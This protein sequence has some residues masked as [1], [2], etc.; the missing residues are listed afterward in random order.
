ML[1]AIIVEDDASEVPN[2]FLNMPEL[3]LLFSHIPAHDLLNRYASVTGDALF[4]HEDNNVANGVEFTL[5]NGQ[6]QPT[7]SMVQGKWTRMRLIFSSLTTSLELQMTSNTIGCEWHLL[8]KDGIYVEGAPRRFGE[9]VYMG[10][11]NRVDVV[12]KCASSGNVILGTATMANII[13]IVVSS[14][15]DIPD[16]ALP[17]FSPYRPDYLADVYTATTTTTFSL[18]FQGVNGGCTVNGNAWDGST[19]TGS[20]VTGSIQEWDVRGVNRHPFHIHVNSYQLSGVTSATDFFMAGDWHD[21]LYAPMGVTVDKYFFAVDSFVTKSVLHCHFLPHEDLGCMGYMQ[22]TG[23]AGAT[24]GLSGHGMSCL[25]TST[26]TGDGTAVYTSA[27]DLVTV[28]PS[29]EPSASPTSVP[30]S[31]P[32]SSPPSTVPTSHPSFTPTY[33]PSHTTSYQLK[34]QQVCLIVC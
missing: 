34:F 6:Y 2:V 32:I 4:S 26:A 13:T 22:H 15:A 7:A 18:N 21:V 28:A 9:T 29:S 25:G 24:T 12:M 10:P 31:M 17:Q 1:G 5:V 27:C 8:A 30:S 3:V 11:G 23:T 20:M 14:T 33:H 19:A 16:I